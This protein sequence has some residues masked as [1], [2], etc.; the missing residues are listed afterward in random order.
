MNGALIFSNLAWSWSASGD[1]SCTSLASIYSLPLAGGGPVS[2]PHTVS[3][4]PRREGQPAQSG[5]SDA[6]L[7]GQ[8]SRRAKLISKYQICTAA[9]IED[10]VQEFKPVQPLDHP[11]HDSES[12][13]ASSYHSIRLNCLRS[14]TPRRRPLHRLAIVTP[15]LL[16]A[17]HE[18][19]RPTN[20]SRSSIGRSAWPLLN[21]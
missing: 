12:K 17:C 18:Y 20:R 2:T 13:S 9:K 11:T 21:G 6:L 14:H 15:L 5:G 4:G 16:F 7:L 19:P 3:R 10:K 1:G 8:P